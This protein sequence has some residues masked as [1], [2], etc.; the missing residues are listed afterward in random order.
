MTAA[1]KTDLQSTNH[2][3]QRKQKIKRNEKEKPLSLS[4]SESYE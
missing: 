1:E 2:V 3:N 4:S